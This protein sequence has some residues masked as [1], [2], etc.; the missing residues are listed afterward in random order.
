MFFSNLTMLYFA[1]GANMCRE[2]MGMRCPQACEIGSAVLHG[3]RFLIMTDGYASV[4]PAAG[5]SVHGVLWRLTPRDLGALDIFENLQ[6]GLYR[7]A[8]RPV[9]AGSARRRALVYIGHTAREGR[10]KPGYMDVV[11]AAARDWNLPPHYIASLRRLA[12]GAW[13][14][15]HP[16]ETGGIG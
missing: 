12:P 11:L 1:Y 15:K 2:G 16:A 9:M 8:A 10:P 7:R 13:R 14:G 4:A 6:G 3:H 5:E